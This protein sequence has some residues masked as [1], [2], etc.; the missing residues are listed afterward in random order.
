MVDRSDFRKLKYSIP[1]LCALPTGVKETPVGTLVID[2][3]VA[4][5]M[6]RYVVLHAYDMPDIAIMLDCASGKLLHILSPLSWER[7]SR[8]AERHFNKFL[9][10]IKAYVGS[11]P[12][13]ERVKLL[14]NSL[15][16]ES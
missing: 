4:G 6:M 8:E 1:L 12:Q 13:E 16:V 3:L 11:L 14:V 10:A 15:K 5:P 9:D 2:R 7:D